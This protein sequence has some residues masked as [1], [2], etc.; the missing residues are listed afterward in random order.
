MMM[1]EA[2]YSF[3]S[4]GFFN[5]AQESVRAGGSFLLQH[6][7]AFPSDQ[8]LD[9][10][11]ELGEQPWERHLQPNMVLRH[12]DRAAGHLAESA[13]A[14]LQ[15]IARPDLFL[16]RN[17]VLEIWRQAAQAGLQTPRC[18]FP[19]QTMGNGQDKGF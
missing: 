10:F 11:D 16:D 14:E 8:R 18:L 12:I 13:K 9:L 17:H 6:E 7:R 3:S 19:P 15:M 4:V 2:A 5:D 1:V